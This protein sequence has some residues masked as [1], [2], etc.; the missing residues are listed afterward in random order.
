MQDSI[1]TGFINSAKLWA[2]KAVGTSRD[3]MPIISTPWPSFLHLQSHF[4]VTI[5]MAGADFHWL[6]FANDPRACIELH[7]PNSWVHPVLTHQTQWGI[8]KADFCHRHKISHLI[9]CRQRFFFPNYFFIRLLMSQQ[10]GVLLL[11]YLRNL[12]RWWAGSSPPHPTPPLPFSL[13]GALQALPCGLH[14]A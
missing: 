1:K 11:L 12:I 8:Y 6:S 7:I 5:V 3:F 10:E 2:L 4:M 13:P 14:P 9:L